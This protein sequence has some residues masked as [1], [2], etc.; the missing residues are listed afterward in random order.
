MIKIKILGSECQ[1]SGTYA[2]RAKQA[3]K[4]DI[5]L[6]LLNNLAFL[7]PAADRAVSK[8][9]LVVSPVAHTGFSGLVRLVKKM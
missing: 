4:K 6:C 9:P 2:K 3:T 8:L 5:S 7:Q 1:T